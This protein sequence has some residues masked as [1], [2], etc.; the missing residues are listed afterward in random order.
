MNGQWGEWIGSS[1]YGRVW[2]YYHAVEW[3][4]DVLKRFLLVNLYQESVLSPLVLIMFFEKTPM[5]TNICKWHIVLLAE[6]EWHK[7]L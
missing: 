4:A 3:I 1:S 7:G 5:K 6:T 2:E